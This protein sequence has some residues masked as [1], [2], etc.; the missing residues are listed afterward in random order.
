MREALRGPQHQDQQEWSCSVWSCDMWSQVALET[1]SSPAVHKEP[2]L[3]HCFCFP[4]SS[5][6]CPK[7][8]F[9]TTPSQSQATC[10]EGPR[11]SEKASAQPPRSPGSKP[12]TFLSLW[13]QG[14]EASQ[15]GSV[16][17]WAMRQKSAK[18]Q[19]QNSKA[20]PNDLHDVYSKLG[21]AVDI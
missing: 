12:A 1:E 9:P 8:G 4:A 3:W 20:R 5:E 2:Q 6:A 18:A 7:L 10:R 17:L 15:R 21:F 14:Q 19:V 16:S 13:D 11:P